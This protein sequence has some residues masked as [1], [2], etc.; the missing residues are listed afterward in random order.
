LE[1]LPLKKNVTL[2]DNIYYFG[3]IDFKPGI[4]SYKCSGDI[5]RWNVRNGIIH[6]ELETETI[7]HLLADQE[8]VILP[9]SRFALFITVK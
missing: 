3:N 2:Q 8:P 7:F 6:I 4:I 1:C 5:E 9:A